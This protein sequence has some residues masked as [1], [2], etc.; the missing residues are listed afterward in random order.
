MPPGQSSDACS[1]S[2]PVGGVHQ[3]GAAVPCC[4]DGSVIQKDESTNH[5][6]TDKWLE[7]KQGRRGFVIP[8]LCHVVLL[9][10]EIP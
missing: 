2:C 5:C 1:H 10:W 8:C 3:C 9:W 4:P 6:V 7:L